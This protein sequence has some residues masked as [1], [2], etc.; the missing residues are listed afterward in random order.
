MNF[1]EK[2]RIDVTF[3]G[4]TV[5]KSGRPRKSGALFHSTAQIFVGVYGCPDSAAAVVPTA[6]MICPADT[7]SPASTLGLAWRL[8]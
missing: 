1:F 2:I 6:P 7:G 4:K 3:P 8:A 5:K